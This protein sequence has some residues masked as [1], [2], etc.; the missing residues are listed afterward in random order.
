M[1]KYRRLRRISNI[2]NLRV[3]NRVF[4]AA[5]FLIG[6]AIISRPAPSQDKKKDP[7]GHFNT[8]TVHQLILT[9]DSGINRGHLGVFPK[10]EAELTLFGINNDTYKNS[11]SLTA[12]TTSSIIEVSGDKNVTL[13]G[14]AGPT[15]PRQ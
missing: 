13:Y 14:P 1:T 6:C 3:S 5:V 4:W 11:I 9:D 12:D 8:L 7:D 2:S 15:K 10:G